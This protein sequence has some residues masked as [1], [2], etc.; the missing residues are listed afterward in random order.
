MDNTWI[1]IVGLLLFLLTFLGGFPIWLSLTLSAIVIGIFYSDMSPQNVP[2]VFLGSLD[3]FTLLAVPFFMLGGNIMAHCGPSKYLFNAIDASIGHIPGGLPF[4]TV[5]TCMI[6]AAITGSTLATLVSVGTIA[7]PPMVAMGYPKR[8]CLGLL[9]VSGT[10]GQIIP[11]SIYMILYGS[12]VQE[13]AAKLFA[14]GMLPGIIMGVLIGLLAMYISIKGKYGQRRKAL[15][16]KERLHHL[17]MGIPAMIMPLIVL[18]GIYTGVFTPTEAAAVACIYA[19]LVSALFYK[20]LTKTTLMQ[21][22]RGALSTNSMIF[23]IVAAAVLFAGP[24][25]YAHIPQNLTNFIIAQ[26]FGKSGF[27]VLSVALFL[28]L[29]CFLDPLPILYLTIPIL[30]HPIQALGIDLIHFCIITIICMQIA[31]VTPPFGVSL[32][33]TSQLWDEPIPNVIKASFPFLILLILTLPLFLF[34]PWLSKWLPS[35]M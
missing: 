35:L 6:F 17:V 31:Q 5:V 27:L 24:L 12:Y 29:G 34:V 28:V 26:G 8:F 18:G 20:G 2:M 1:L 30:Y 16:K 22:L 4:A 9:C 13:S 32:Y 23:L 15:P 7:V 3:S 11:P 21:S 25:T 14:G 19:V 33:T 10:L